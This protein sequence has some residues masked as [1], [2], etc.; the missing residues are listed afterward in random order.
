MRQTEKKAPVKNEKSSC[1][2]GTELG[3][4]KIHENVV[5]SIVR[6]VALS[7]DGVARL[8]GSSFVDNIAE[9]VGS[10]RMHDRAIAIVMEEDTIAIDVK[11]N[12]KFGYKVPELAAAVQSAIIQEVEN[13]TGMNVTGVNVIIQ[14]I[15]EETAEPED[16]EEAADNV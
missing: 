2:K 16:A 1:E 15:E 10:R 7:V 14:E 13:I 12:I 6:K 3:F 8:A 5:S 9:I 4:V 11:L